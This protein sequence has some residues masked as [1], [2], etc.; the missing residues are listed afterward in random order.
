MDGFPSD[1]YQYFCDD[2]D[3]DDKAKKEH[4]VDDVGNYGFLLVQ[5]L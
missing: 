1:V 3:D 2:D 5:T 4:D